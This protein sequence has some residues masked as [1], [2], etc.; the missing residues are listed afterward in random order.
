[1]RPSQQQQIILMLSIHQI[2][3]QLFQ[4]RMS[5]ISQQHKDQSNMCV[6]CGCKAFGS[7]TGMTPVEIK[8]RT[9]QGAGGNMEEAGLTLDMT[10]TNEQ[11]LNFI[12]ER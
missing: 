10:A 6:E 2:Q 5:Q 9:M 8:D 3:N 4:Q 12:N 7:S 1:M 11:R